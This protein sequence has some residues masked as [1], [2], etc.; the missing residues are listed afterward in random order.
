MNFFKNLLGNISIEPLDVKCKIECSC[1]CK[2]S[3]FDASAETGKEGVQTS[4]HLNGK[5][6]S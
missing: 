1:N 4:G 3:S 5:K 2:G 6:V